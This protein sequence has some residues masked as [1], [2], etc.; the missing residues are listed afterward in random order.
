[1]NRHDKNFTFDDM[2][3][4]EIRKISEMMFKESVVVIT[5]EKE[6]ADAKIVEGNKDEEP[7]CPDGYTKNP[8]KTFVTYIY[9]EQS[10]KKELAN[11]MKGKLTLENDQEANAIAEEVFDYI[12]KYKSLVSGN[13]SGNVVGNGNGSYWWPIGSMET[14][15]AN[16][17][18]FATGN[19]AAIVI[20]STYGGRVNPTTGVYQKAHG[21]IDI[22]GGMISTYG[23][24]A[25][26]VIASKDGII[27]SVVTGCF[28]H[29]GSAADSCGG[30]YGNHVIIK[31]SDGNYTLYA[32]MHQNTIT[33]N[34][35]DI[36]AQGQI[37][38]KVGSSGNSTGAHLHFEVRVGQ[39]NGQARQDPETFVDPK[40]PRPS[41]FGSQSLTEFIN[42][43]E[44]AGPA[45]LD[46]NS[47]VVYAD[48]GGVLTVGYG[49]AIQYNLDRLSA[50]GIDGNSLHA[51]DLV[52]KILVDQVK[53][54]VI[55]AIYSDITSLLSRE[56]ITLENYQ[57]DALVSRAYNMGNV[58]DF[59]ENYK[60]Y[61][62]TQPLYDNY[63]SK[64]ITDRAGNELAGLVKR[65][66]AEWNLFHNGVY[67]NHS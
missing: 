59:P 1:M 47:Y 25:V 67:Q 2:T 26:P 55:S 3:E 61:G 7:A 57:I 14:T 40:N 19:P 54:Q 28:T 53:Q 62:N 4:S 60:K 56:G 33:V 32:H 48:S 51:G 46:E 30:G 23:A 21:A 18:L 44:G 66:A 34:V 9:D 50:V 39:N 13:N 16:G 12:D 31:H 29:Q 5:C 41:A 35:G 45:S 22:A 49:I 38:G 10:F 64:P 17:H 58:V 36:V 27:E 43:F 52:P 65:R 63:M 37:I 24:G 20:T 15:E 11:Y 6:G 42:S 8:D